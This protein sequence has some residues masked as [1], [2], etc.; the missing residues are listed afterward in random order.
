MIDI[1][2]TQIHTGTVN[3]ELPLDEFSSKFIALTPP[4]RRML[5]GASEG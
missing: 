3:P 5:N 2:G 1:T 4:T